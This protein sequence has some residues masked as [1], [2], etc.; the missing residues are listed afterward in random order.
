M[1]L[2]ELGVSD[3]NMSLLQNLYGNHRVV[4][5]AG[6]ESRQ[7]AFGRGV[8]QGGPISVLLFNFV[9]EVCVSEH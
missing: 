2:R 9:M 4:V 8:K 7:F 3:A 6:K 1:A 5:D